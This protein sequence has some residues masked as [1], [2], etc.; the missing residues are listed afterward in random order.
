MIAFFR[1]DRFRIDVELGPLVPRLTINNP[2]QG[3]N[4]RCYIVLN[5]FTENLIQVVMKRALFWCCSGLMFIAKETV[6]S[7]SKIRLD[8]NTTR[9]GVIMIQINTLSMAVFAIFVNTSALLSFS[10]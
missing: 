3:A 1:G 2:K 4:C 8:Q 7:A 6:R 9:M 5:H 10:V